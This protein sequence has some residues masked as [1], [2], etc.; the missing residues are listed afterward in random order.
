MNLIVFTPLIFGPFYAKMSKRNSF[1]RK[2]MKKYHLVT[3]LLI[4]S[5][6]LSSTICVA[7]PS[8]H[9]DAAIEYLKAQHA[10][11]S[12]QKGALFMFELKIQRNPDLSSFRDIIS[13]WVQKHY[14]WENLSPAMIK[15]AMDV[16]TEA[17]LREMTAFYL[18][19]TGQKLLEKNSE[20][21]RKSGE[22][23]TIVFEK[24]KS[25]LDK[26]FEE[27]IKELASTKQ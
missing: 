21:M 16:F 23:T 15:V 22:I 10:I 18:T 5:L 27:R 25:D 26:M 2:T 17:E 11:E 1:R 12:T 6:F 7:M 4:P 8:S 20:L 3:L 13:K 9:R 24:Y 19:S 14:T